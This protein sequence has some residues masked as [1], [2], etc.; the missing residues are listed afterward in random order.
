MSLNSMENQKDKS[1]L[2]LDSFLNRKIIEN[3]NKFQNIFKKSK[4]KRV[5]F[6]EDKIIINETINITNINTPKASNKNQNK[7]II[8]NNKTDG[9][10]FYKRKFPIK[11]KLILYFT[12]K[13][14]IKNNVYNFNNNKKLVNRN[15][16]YNKAY[17]RSKNK[18]VNNSACMSPSNYFNIKNRNKQRERL[19]IRNKPNITLKNKRPADYNSKKDQC[20][21]PSPKSI[22][23][24]KMI[25]R[26]K[27]EENKKKDWNEKEKIKK[28]EEEKKSCLIIQKSNK[29]ENYKT[30][31]GLLERQK[32]N[33]E[34]KQQKEENLKILL[35]KKKEE[36][37]NK[38]NFLMQKNKEKKLNINGNKKL[39]N[40]SLEKNK[41]EKINN[42]ISKLY[43]WD[44]KRKEKLDMNMKNFEKE[45][46]KHIPTINK[47][48]ASMAEIK[49]EKYRE[50]NIF[51]RLS[52]VDPELAE[53]K[54]LLKELY[55][56]T[57][58]PNII[59]RD[60]YK[61]SKKKEKKIVENY[62]KDEYE[63]NE[64]NYESED[65]SKEMETIYI[66]S[67]SNQYIQDDNVQDLYRNAIFQNKKKN[68]KI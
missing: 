46:N 50:K 3:E 13:N 57:F 47:R 63:E 42:S 44:M 55:T 38:N 18:S 20:L 58:K 22:N 16:Y 29:K 4:R 14:K 62:D 64:V 24:Q 60:T 34:L 45:K 59:T 61:S 21:S 68:S 66:T 28:E 65:D 56:P 10:A 49:K 19:A 30:K 5:C 37:I 35:S 32:K 8:K 26:F 15:A 6:S 41:K 9:N 17:Q 52:K 48:S 31:D 53:R 33:D 43:D 23:F 51:N 2:K 27:N 39:R 1:I 40:K 25:G 67:I 12:P 11:K 7:K 36:E 54:K